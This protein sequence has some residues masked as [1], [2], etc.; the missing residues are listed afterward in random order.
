[1]IDLTLIQI[2][3][4][5]GVSSFSIFWRVGGRA[6]AQL[7]Q[8]ILEGKLKHREANSGRLENAPDALNQLF[9]GANIG[10]LLVKVAN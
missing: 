4:L 3:R 8:W 7:V 6:V 5:C 1:M 2:R 10:N 9:D